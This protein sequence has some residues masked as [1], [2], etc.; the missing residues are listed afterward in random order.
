MKNKKIEK[1][2]RKKRNHK[3][4]AS[5]LALLNPICL[6]TRINYLGLEPFSALK[7]IRFLLIGIVGLLALCFVVKLKA[8]YTISLILLELILM[9]SVYYIGLRNKYENKKFVDVSAYLEQMLYSFKRRPKILSSLK[10][11][12][13][14][15]EDE[16]DGRFRKAIDSA[17]GHIQ[18]GEV[19]GDVYQEAFGY[20]EEEYGCK[21]VYKTHAFLTRVENAGG[22][23]EE[24]IGILLNDRNLW[25][26]RI[27]NLLNDKNKIRIN[28]T[29]GIALS[30]I[31]VTMCVYM[32]PAEFGIYLKTVSQTA[33]TLTIGLDML[34]WYFVQVALG[35]SLLDAD[36]DLPFEEVER[37]YN[38][39]MHGQS[40]SKNRNFMIAAGMCIVGAIFAFFS[41]GTV[42]AI[43]L[44]L[45]SILM[46]TQP[47]RQYKVCFKRVKR[48]VEKAFPDWLLSLALQMQTD[49]LHV[50]IIKTSLDAPRI[51]A[52]EL[53]KLQDGIEVKPDELEPFA[54]FFK[55]LEIADIM[56]A[57]KMLYAMDQFGAADSQ[58]QIKALVDRNTEIMDK[59]ERMRLEDH[60][61]GISFAMLFPMLT[62][63]ISMLADL[64]LVM[65]YILGQ[66]NF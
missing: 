62:G 61:A 31:V 10:D 43:I 22:D 33:R 55:K 66:V 58:E 8:I 52:E 14:L 59:A 12:A 5:F 19:S 65:E 3:V 29:I 17:I 40:K 20:I 60:L 11:A 24:A 4:D 21:R 54:E 16:K 32:L 53:Q 49:N 6:K 23:P 37:S 44:A 63:V 25:V 38:I 56:T 57:M 26:S 64:V 36:K 35:K 34:I 30:L 45:F 47:K 15:F 39:V 13:I 18:Y 41:M 7:Y 28:V 48:E 50:S 2:V 42:P 46:V 51:M 27:Q 9:P 1:A